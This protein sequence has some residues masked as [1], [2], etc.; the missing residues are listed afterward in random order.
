MK[1]LDIILSLDAAV[2]AIVSDLSATSHPVI[3]E[4]LTPI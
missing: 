1:A 4:V 3:I 2:I